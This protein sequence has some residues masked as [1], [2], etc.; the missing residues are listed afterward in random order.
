ME[1]KLLKCDTCGFEIYLHKNYN[2]RQTLKLLREH[3][4]TAGLFACTKCVTTI[5]NKIK[6]LRSKLCQN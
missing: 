1:I 3:L 4:I 2:D 6:L 5:K